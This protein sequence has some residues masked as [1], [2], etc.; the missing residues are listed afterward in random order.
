VI[1]KD[2][3]VSRFDLLFGVDND[4]IR[5]YRRHLAEIESVVAAEMRRN[6]SLVI[7]AIKPSVKKATRV[8]AGHLIL[9][10]ASLRGG[11]VPEAPLFVRAG[12][13]SDVFRRF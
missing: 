8:D 3:P 2:D 9:F 6:E 4:T 13:R 12:S 7:Y 10:G 5:R 1:D 11:E